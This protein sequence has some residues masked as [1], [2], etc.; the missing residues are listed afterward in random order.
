MVGRGGSSPERDAAREVGPAARAASW[1]RF[2]GH[3]SFLLVGLAIGV[4]T[5]IGAL[6]VGIPLLTGLGALLIVL[7]AVAVWNDYRQFRSFGRF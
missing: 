7:C 6:K 5:L 4:V 1:W 2:V 3:S